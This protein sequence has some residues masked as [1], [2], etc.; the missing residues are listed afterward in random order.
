[1]IRLVRNQNVIGGRSRP[2]RP[3]FVP[4]RIIEEFL[5]ISNYTQEQYEQVVSF[6]LKMICFFFGNSD[7]FYFKVSYMSYLGGSTSEAAMNLIF[8]ECFDNDFCRRITWSGYRNTL[9]IRDTRWQDILYGK[10]FECKI[11]PISVHS[12]NF[13]TLQ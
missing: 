4:I 2:R 7:N 1:M 5:A 6:K 12:K 10:L 9:K 8:P 11:F 3:N 13:I